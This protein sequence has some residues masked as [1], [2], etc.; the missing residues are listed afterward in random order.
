MIKDSGNRTA[1]TTGAV[2]DIQVGKRTVR[3][4][5]SS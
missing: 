2:R 5:T 4:I 1:F 3:F